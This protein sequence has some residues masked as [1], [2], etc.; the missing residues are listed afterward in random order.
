MDCSFTLSPMSIFGLI[1]RN[2]KL[3]H[4]GLPCRYLRAT[5]SEDKA[6]LG[7]LKASPQAPGQSTGVAGLKE[8][9]LSAN[10]TV[11]SKGWARL[12][13]AVAH[14]SQLRV[15]NLDY[16]PLDNGAN[17]VK[18]AADSGFLHIR[19]IALTPH[20]VVTKSLEALSQPIDRE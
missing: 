13:I 12:A 7:S 5:E 9:T 3:S 11:T 4:Q 19:Y 10:P 1:G 17:M 16:N 14:S 2:I 18:A 6:G 15:L 20:H 8:L